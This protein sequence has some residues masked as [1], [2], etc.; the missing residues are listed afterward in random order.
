M[1]TALCSDNMCSNPLEIICFY[2][3]F[4]RDFKVLTTTSNFPYKLRMTFPILRWKSRVRWYELI[5]LGSKGVWQ[6]EKG[7][8]RYLPD[9]L[10]QRK[11]PV[12]PWQS[13]PTVI[14]VKVLPP[15]ELGDQP[16]PWGS[17]NQAE[18]TGHR[19]DCCLLFERD[20]YYNWPQLYVLIVK[21]KLQAWNSTKNK[22]ER[23]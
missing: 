1:L 12:G 16:A 9:L 13:L 15:N 7:L 6:N 17:R 8:F 4:K 21:K 19:S 3:I 5:D 23:G 22:T 14:T 18:D 20:S 10:E 11:E 2:S